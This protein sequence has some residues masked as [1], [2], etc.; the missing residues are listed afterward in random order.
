VRGFQCSSCIMMRLR[1]W[2]RQRPTLRNSL[3]AVD[4]PASAKP[5]DPGPSICWLPAGE[6]RA[7]GRASTSGQPL[8]VDWRTASTL[9]IA[10][11]QLHHIQIRE[12]LRY[13]VA[14]GMGSPVPQ[15]A[16]WPWLYRRTQHFLHRNC[17]RIS[18]KQCYRVTQ[19]SKS[20]S[21]LKA[22]QVGSSLTLAHI[23]LPARRS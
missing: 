20:R 15:H 9:P 21:Q 17:F 5:P 3:A 6:P 10:E 1:I 16:F 7:P 14:L 11:L 23:P 19:S 12:H 4:S 8:K 13:I 18:T 2:P 22:E